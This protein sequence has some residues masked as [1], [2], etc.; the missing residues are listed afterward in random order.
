M[1]SSAPRTAR[2]YPA[3][4]YNDVLALQW[5]WAGAPC[6]WRRNVTL[7]FTEV[8]FSR[9]ERAGSLTHFDV[10]DRWRARLWAHQPLPPLVVCATDHGSF[11]IHDGN[12][13][14]AAMAEYFGDMAAHARVRVALVVPRS[15][16]HFQYRWFGTY[17]TYVLVR[18]AKQGEAKPRSPAP[19]S[20]A[21]GFVTPLMAAA[22]ICGPLQ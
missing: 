3:V 2:Y 10:L 18:V 17:G 12:H 1:P 5:L 16:Y 14:Y 22:A 21:G 7:R 6:R 9:L 8:P 13:R 11:Y 19:A 20:S 4:R 15:G